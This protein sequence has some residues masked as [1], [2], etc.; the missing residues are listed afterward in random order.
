[1]A[2][3]ELQRLAAQDGTMADLA[4]FLQ[5]VENAPRMDV[6]AADRLTF[7]AA[8]EIYL[9]TGATTRLEQY[10]T[11]YPTGAYRGTAWEY[12]MQSAVAAG[13]TRDAL[14]YAEAVIEH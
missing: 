10:L 2:V 13:N 8:E 9:R 3:A 7:E 11:D 4:T 12:M 6:V 14:S 5:S 1:M